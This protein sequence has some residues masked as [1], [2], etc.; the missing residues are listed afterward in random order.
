V[1]RRY[2]DGLS[3]CGLKKAQSTNGSKIRDALEALPPYD[4]VINAMHRIY[5]IRRCLMRNRFFVDFAQWRDCA[6][7]IDLK[8]IYHVQKY[9]GVSATSCSLCGGVCRACFVLFTWFVYVTQARL[10]AQWSS[11]RSEL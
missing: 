2:Y 3:G 7:E 10:V 1:W 9:N 8:K 4:G 6:G 11:E 5:E